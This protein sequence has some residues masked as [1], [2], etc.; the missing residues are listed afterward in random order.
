MLFIGSVTLGRKSQSIVYLLSGSD[1]I[2]WILDLEG[3]AHSIW[4]LW[5]SGLQECK[6]NFL[7]GEVGQGR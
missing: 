7:G 1:H 6:D 5:T 4:I 3:E 2:Y